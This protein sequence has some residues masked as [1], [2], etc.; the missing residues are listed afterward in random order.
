MR[1]RP[2][3]L[4]AAPALAAVLLAVLS[5]G[6]LALGALR[7]A[8]AQVFEPTIF[9]LDNGLQVVVVA[10]SRAPVVT[11][12]IWYKVGSADEPRGK[13]GIAHFL[14]HLMFKGTDS[15]A[16]GEFSDIVAR[17]GG[18]ENA[19]TSYDYTGYYQ[20]VARD[21]L[22][23]MMEL[24]ADRMA[25]LALTDAVVLPEREVILEER[26]QRIDNTPASQLQEMARGSLWLHH[27]YGTPI[28]GWES[29]MSALDTQDALDFYESWYAPNNAVLIVAGDVDPE[30]VRALAEEHYGP[31]PRKEVPPRRRVEEP[32]HWAGARVE[33]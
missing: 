13:S 31:I 6:A 24:E 11:Q 23:L 3:P 4:L 12:M 10:N 22:A 26:R 5:F 15:R 30:A 14:E 18:R 16:P 7:P 27:P 9:E 25:N 32:H 19:F 21:R 29:E 2:V 8:G 1:S 17:H 28:I 33:L 20:T